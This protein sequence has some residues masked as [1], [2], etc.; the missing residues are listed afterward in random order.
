MC[1]LI[2]D[3]IRASFEAATRKKAS[4]LVIPRSCLLDVSVV[5]QLTYGISDSR[6]QEAVSYMDQSSRK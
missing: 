6:L 3:A 5:T 1:K 4:V 2:I